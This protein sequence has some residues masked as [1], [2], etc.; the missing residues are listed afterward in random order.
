MGH[1]STSAQKAE[2]MAVQNLN[3]ETAVAA[4]HD[5]GLSDRADDWSV[6]I[7]S[8]KDRMFWIRILHAVGPAAEVTDFRVPGLNCAEAGQALSA[9]LALAGHGNIERIVFKDITPSGQNVQMARQ[10]LLQTCHAVAAQRRQFLSKTWSQ[11][12]RGKIH[13]FVC[14][15]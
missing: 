9:A 4:L 2:Q 11:E 14:F 7:S 5:L 10:S 12:D 13:Y 1:S 15:D 3:S 6:Q 8:S